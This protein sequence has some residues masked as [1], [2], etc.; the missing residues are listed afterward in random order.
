LT[1]VKEDATRQPGATLVLTEEAQMAYDAGELSLQAPIKV[2]LNGK[3]V[4]TT[5]GRLIFYQDLPSGLHYHLN[6]VVDKKMLGRLVSECYHR[7]GIET[8]V[9]MLD[10][11][12]ELGFHFATIAGITISVDD[13]IRAQRTKTDILSRS[14]PQG[15]R[16]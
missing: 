4:E 8:A 15:G 1:S 14:R 7:F 2:R 11:V 6:E 16:N 9:E 13:T 3:Q 10:K 12:K 5:L